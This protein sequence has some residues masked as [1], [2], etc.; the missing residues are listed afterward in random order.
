[1][2]W[3]L[4]VCHKKE[5]VEHINPFTMAKPETCSYA[6][7]PIHQKEWRGAPNKLAQMSADMFGEL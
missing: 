6:C 7:W 2:M 5:D 3:A 1:M 4:M